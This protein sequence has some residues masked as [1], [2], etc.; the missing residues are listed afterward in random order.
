MRPLLGHLPFDCPLMF[1]IPKFSL[2]IEVSLC[3]ISVTFFSASDRY[4]SLINMLSLLTLV[5]QCFWSYYLWLALGCPLPF[6]CLY[7]C[8]SYSLMGHAFYRLIVKILFSS[9]YWLPCGV[10]GMVDVCYV[11]CLFFVVSASLK[12]PNWTI[13]RVLCSLRMAKWEGVI[14]SFLAT[15]AGRSSSFDH[16]SSGGSAKDDSS[17]V[18]RGLQCNPVWLHE[19]PFLFNLASSFVCHATM[20]LISFHSSLSHSFISLPLL[21]IWYTFPRLLSI[22]V[23]GGSCP[24]ILLYIFL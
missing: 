20:N 9:P 22:I 1:D 21:R 10:C 13:N 18:A 12:V 17:Y 24:I 15:V 7:F 6:S 11:S 14:L 23:M 4:L 3:C 5:V 16:Y 19:F 2:C 8:N